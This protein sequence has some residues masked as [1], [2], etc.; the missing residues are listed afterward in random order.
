MRSELK[1]D[2]MNINVCWSH[3]KQQWP[4]RRS[5]KKKKKQNRNKISVIIKTLSVVWLNCFLKI[6]LRI[7]IIRRTV[8][9]QVHWCYCTLNW[10]ST[11]LLDHCQNTPSHSTPPTLSSNTFCTNIFVFISI[12]LNHCFGIY[13]WVNF[14]C[15]EYSHNSHYSLKM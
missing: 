12:Q 1:L 8:W 10:S 6:S 14:A 9:P 2:V 3:R 11:H 4:R 15:W 7:G 13:F 5:N